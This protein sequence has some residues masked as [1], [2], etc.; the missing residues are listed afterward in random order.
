MNAGWSGR[1]RN[2]LERGPTA[3]FGVT[4]AT[5]VASVGLPELL[6]LG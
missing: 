5:A 1:C 3:P 2:S 4:E 6:Y